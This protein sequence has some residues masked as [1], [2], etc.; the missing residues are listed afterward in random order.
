MELKSFWEEVPVNKKNQSKELKEG[1]LQAG[2]HVVRGDNNAVYGDV[3]GD[4]VHGDKIT[5]ITLEEH[6]AALEEEVEIRTKQLKE[7]YNK[8]QQRDQQKIELLEKVLGFT[9]SRL[10]NVDQ[11][12]KKT[13]QLLAEATKALERQPS[14]PKDQFAE[15]EAQLNEGK[16]EKAEALF[17]QVLK[18]DMKSAAEA[19]Y[20]I[21]RLAENKIDYHKA[22]QNY[23]WAAKLNPQN[24]MY[25]NDAGV[26]LNI[27]GEYDEATEYFEKTLDLDLNSV[28]GKDSDVASDWN[29]LGQIWDSKG[30]YDKAIE[31]YEKALSIRQALPDPPDADIGMNFSDL[32]LAWNNKGNFE[33]AVEYYEKA[34]E[35]Y[36][37]SIGEKHS[38]VATCW[39]NLGAVWL[40]QGEYDKALDFFN[41]ALN[42]D[43]NNFGEGHPHVARDWNNVG[44]AWKAKKNFE[45]AITFYGKA[46]QSDLNT[47]GENHPNVAV[48]WKNLGTA[49][50]AMGDISK[51][52]EF[53]EKALASDVK[54]FGKEH[55]IVA[56]RM[57][58]L[59][60][61]LIDNNEYDKA[62]KLLN[63]SMQTN[64]KSF[65]QAHHEIAEN[66]FYIGQL[67]DRQKKV[68]EALEAY[69][70][71]RIMFVKFKLE[72]WVDQVNSSLKSLLE[73]RDS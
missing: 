54:N 62:L 53:L 16:T 66:L 64:I 35:K 24:R 65:G 60:S 9:E 1:N 71:A 11:D 27:L 22:L 43:L 5:G 44:A 61:A 49:F 20:Q 33:K 3:D 29:N 67:Y 70:K 28:D 40:D 7:E 72:H 19:A 45:K 57:K 14:I 52:V 58:F 13:K 50:Q 69:Q 25:L 17:Q 51:A 18:Q 32:G 37:K 21:A 34:L 31:C 26:L 68:D 15:A 30:K 36:K 56:N 10:E 6:K 48:R 39:N 41:K 12:L 47:L 23:K 38:W 4:V 73:K 63:R 59:G 46:L 2:G 42:S 55:P 8:G